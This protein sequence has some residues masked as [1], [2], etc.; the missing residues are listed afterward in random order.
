M[1][2]KW[3]TMSLAFLVTAS[4]IAGCSSGK[5]ANSGSGKADNVQNV[6]DDMKEHMTINMMIKSYE[7][8]GWPENHPVIDYLD[9]KFNIDL[10]IQWIPSDS[11]EEKLNVLVASGNF[12]DTFWLQK[13][14]FLKWRDKG[15]YLDVKPFLSK[16]PNLLKNLGG[17]EAFQLM[18]P[19]GKYYGLP[20]YVVETRNSLGIRQDWLD[21]LQLKMPATIDD[22]YN[23]AKAFAK[24]DPDGDG[25]DDTLGFSASLTPDKTD[26]AHIDPLKATFGLVNQWGVKD[27]KLINWHTQN[28]ELKDFASFMQKAYAEGVLDRDFAVNKTK[29]PQDKYAADK[30][31]TTDVNPA[32]FDRYESTLKKIAPQAVTSQL[33]PP[34]GPNGAQ[35]TTTF[36]AGE[37][38]IVIN[39]KI[40]PKKQDRILKL[41]D[42]FVSDE[43]DALIKNGI[44]G[45]D[46]KKDGDQYTKLDAFD[47]DRPQIL[48]SWFL[49]R[50]DLNFSG[51]LWDDP[52]E[53]SKVTQWYKNNEPFKWPNV[54]IGLTSDTDNK[55]G[56]TINQK[57]MSALVKIIMGEAPIDM[58]DQAVEQWK[59]DG[60]DKITQ[61]YN[62]AYQQLQK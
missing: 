47:K 30:V 53:I 32:G 36:A 31:G 46:Y 25:K 40:D 56:T 12:P 58:I 42:Y 1:K 10:K 14:D 29:D 39:A 13:E 45:L 8:G 38:K 62:D 55:V 6:Q 17:D 57:F 52:K 49:R 28:Q 43:G 34:K 23:V 5:S 44:E 51:N 54:S 59:K 11:Y 41:M 18:S 19:K 27:G 4:M 9:K 24:Q 21:K 15:L 33:L 37:S 61:E 60:G 20:Y 2:K 7:G 16:Y 50:F 48:S 22:F 26:F 35:G 3:L